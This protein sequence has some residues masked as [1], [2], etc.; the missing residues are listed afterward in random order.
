MYSTTNSSE[1]NLINGWIQKTGAFNQSSHKIVHLSTNDLA[2][3]G[4]QLMLLS[5]RYTRIE[6]KFNQRDTLF[7]AM[8]AV[9]IS[10]LMMAILFSRL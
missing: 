1:L 8:F 2:A 4:R 7:L 10:S 6:E 5:C 9:G 3:Q